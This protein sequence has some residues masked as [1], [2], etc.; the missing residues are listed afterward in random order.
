LAQAQVHADKVMTENTPSFHISAVLFQEGEWWSAQCL[1]Y[2]IAAQARTLADLRY[3]LERV[4]LSHVVVSAELGRSPFEGLK[5]APQRFWDMY[6]ASSMRIE[7][8]ELP[9]R[10]PHPTPFATITPRLKVAE[11]RADAPA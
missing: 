7:S 4:L 1:E 11:Q 3:E 9:F 2:D 6:A 8:D 10:L 5:P